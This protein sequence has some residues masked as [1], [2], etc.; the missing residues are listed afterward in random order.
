MYAKSQDM[1][2]WLDGSIEER[3]GQVAEAVSRAVGAEVEMIAT[4]DDCA[5]F[6]D[7]SGRLAEAVFA[8]NGGVI[9]NVEIRV[10]PIPVYEDAQLPRLVADELKEIAHGMLH[11][12]PMTRTRVRVLA[13]LLKK[14]EDYWLGDVI[15]YM[16]CA[17]LS[18]DAN[19]WH[20]AYQANQEKIRTAMW[21]SIRELEARI[22]KTAYAKIPSGRLPEFNEELHESL[23]I[24]STR[25]SEIVDGIS[26]LVFDETDG[27][28]GAIRQSLIAEAQLLRGLLAK[29]EQLMRAEDIDRMALAHDRLC[30]RARTMEVVAAYL[31]GRSKKGAEETK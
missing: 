7:P 5:L 3:I 10:D 26:G 8:I 15:A 12:E 4:K 21:G 24:V 23:G 20:V 6:R 17:M 27:F 9:E 2:K 18:E 31:K 1:K 19:N 22:P 30:G 25:L 14:D 11:G 16:D 29:A 13:G 28:Y